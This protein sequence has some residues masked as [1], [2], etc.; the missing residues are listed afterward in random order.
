MTRRDERKIVAKNAHGW[1]RALHLA[2]Q[3]EYYSHPVVSRLAS[4]Q[5]I[6]FSWLVCPSSK[7]TLYGSFY[8][9]LR[10]TD[11]NAPVKWTGRF[12]QT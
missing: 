5:L 2:Y 7:A 1:I 12:P 8:D 10:N 9:I 4:T 6:R 11:P 3:T